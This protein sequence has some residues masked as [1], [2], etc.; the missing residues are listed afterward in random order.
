[1]VKALLLLCMGCQVKVLPLCM[2][3]VS[4]CPK[5]SKDQLAGSNVTDDDQD[6]SPHPVKTSIDDPSL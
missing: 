1:M 6:A 2:V 4:I 5:L 3:A